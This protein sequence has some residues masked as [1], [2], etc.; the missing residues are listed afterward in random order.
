M[1]KKTPALQGEIEV[2]GDKSISHRALMFAG[3]AKGTSVVT[4]N[5][6]G[7]DNLA[8]LR[9]M[10]QLGMEAEGEFAGEGYEIARE[11]GVTGAGRSKG[12]LCMVR[13]AGSGLSGLHRPAGPLD[14]G[15]SGTT[16]RLLCGLLAGRPFTSTL[17]GDKSLSRRPFKR[18]VDPLTRM[19]AS[20]SGDRLP[21]EVR[22]GSLK[23]IDFYSDKA[24]AQVKSAVLLAGLQAGGPVSVTQPYRSRDH[25]ERMLKA[26]GCRLASGNDERGWKVSMEQPGECLRPFEIRI[27][28]DFSAAAFFFTAASII[29]GSNIL[30]RNVGVNSTR[31]G[32]FSILTRMGAKLELENLREQAGEEVA[33]IVSSSSSLHGTTISAEDVVL[34]I[35]EIPLAVVAAAF[36]EG[37]TIITGAAELRVKESDR[38]SMMAKLLQ[39][40]GIAVEELPDGLVIDGRPD[41]TQSGVRREEPEADACWKDS[42]DHRILM[43]AAILDLALYGTFA[44]YN[45]KVVET[46]FPGFFKLLHSVT[47]E[48]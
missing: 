32:L 38:L 2:P 48:N 21:L 14:C 37:R 10:Q 42:G 17:Q 40:H 18:V 13:L 44:Q 24:S 16:A 25:T 7:R 27:P 23:G 5:L 9:I 6:F 29:P 46:S 1:R 22:G 4:T 12:G 34:A 39:Q 11:E 31:S 35:D 36:A 30:I 45:P 33:D 28:G 47:R 43:C 8:T 20:F 3:L 41:L 26:M 15:N 19:G